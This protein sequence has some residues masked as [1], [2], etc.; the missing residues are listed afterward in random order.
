MPAAE[1]ARTFRAEGH[2]APCPYGASAR[3]SNPDGALDFCRDLIHDAAVWSFVPQG[4]LRFMHT[5]LKTALPTRRGW[6]VVGTTF[7]TLGMVLGVWYSYSVF[8][9]AFLRGFG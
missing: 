1:K 3:A 8:L 5:D 2:G 7:I 6:I 9:V 4:R